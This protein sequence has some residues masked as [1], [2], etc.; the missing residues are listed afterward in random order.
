MGNLKTYSKHKKE[1]KLESKRSIVKIAKADNIL[2]LC[3]HDEPNFSTSCDA[4]M[5]Q[6]LLAER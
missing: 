2:L 5:L 6:Y 3:V 1:R 4:T